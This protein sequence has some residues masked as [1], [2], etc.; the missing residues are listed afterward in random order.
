[1]AVQVFTL[2]KI[3]TQKNRQELRATG[4]TAVTCGMYQTQAKHSP[5]NTVL[6][7]AVLRRQSA[8]FAV[9][10][11]LQMLLCHILA[12]FLIHILKFK[13]NLNQCSTCDD[14][15]TVGKLQHPDKFQSTSNTAVAQ[16]Q[17]K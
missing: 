14:S 3:K 7:C 6:A 5:S 1:M 9:F 10:I 11:Q 12:I 4:R 17:H 8:A 2:K 13:H 15:E 16:L